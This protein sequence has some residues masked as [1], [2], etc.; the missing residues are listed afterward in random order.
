[1]RSRFPRIDRTTALIALGAL[2]LGA[3][4]MVAAT[5]VESRFA[6]IVPSSSSLSKST[7]GLSVWHDYLAR[8]GLAPRLL[9]DFASLPAT[10]TIVAAG[11]FESPASEADADT[12]A[13]WVRAGGRLILVGQDTL[14]LATGIGELTG[15]VS[16]DTTSV[17]SPV[18]PSPYT[19]GVGEI[20]AGSGRFT[21]D[22]PQW[23]ALFADGHGAAV[24]TRRFGAGEVVWLADV[25]P[26]GNTGIGQ[27][28]G[29]AFAVRLAVAGGPGPVY[30]DEYHH[31]LSAQATAWT[32]IGAGG[33]AALVLLF[34]AI[35]VFLL[36]RG[37]RIGPAI[38]RPELPAARGSAYIPQLAELYRTAGARAE[39]LASLEDGLSRAIARRY[40]SR[41]AG[42]SR[43]TGARESLERSGALRASG[44][45]EKDEFV[46]T[47][48]RLRAARNE[49]EGGNG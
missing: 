20:V 27:R 29:A 2:L 12:L 49:V 4:Y 36:A 38:A 5:W 44:R 10:G 6:D 35:A 18:F 8:L 31:G 39:A 46:T 41:E 26:V 16:A 13:A 22:A 7:T 19:S 11:P 33:R 32:R 24:A 34:A 42:L 43:Q 30:F 15:D 25:T 28:D 21:L 1:M 14:D 9:T 3:L 48:A 40:G 47:A 45:I 17:V 23:V 37:R